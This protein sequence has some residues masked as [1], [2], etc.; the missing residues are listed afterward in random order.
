MVCQLH[1]KD[2]LTALRVVVAAIGRDKLGFSLE[3]VGTHSNLSAAAVLS[4]Q[5]GPKNHADGPLVK[6]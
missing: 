1:S 6:L 5:A 3:D 2:A 4:W